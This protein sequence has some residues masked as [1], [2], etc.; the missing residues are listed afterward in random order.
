METIT[1]EMQPNSE[2]RN[3]YNQLEGETQFPG[4]VGK[5]FKWK[6]LKISSEEIDLL[7]ARPSFP[8][9]SESPSSGDE[10]S[11]VK[12]NQSRRRDH[13]SRAIGKSLETDFSHGREYGRT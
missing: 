5:S 3:G 9:P 12:K 11:L 7:K 6:S 13:I 10:Y 2:P 4:P 8:G 1:N